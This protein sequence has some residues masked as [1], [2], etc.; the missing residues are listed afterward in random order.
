[1]RAVFD[2]SRELVSWAA[3]RIPEL[4]GQGF[5]SEAQA[6]GIEDS[7]GRTLGVVVFH[8]YEPWYGTIEVSAVSEDARWMRARD[9]WRRMHQYVF[10][11]CAC[12]KM[13]SRTPASNERAL[14]FLRALGF[15]QEAR[16]PRQFGTDDAVISAKYKEDWQSEQTPHAIAA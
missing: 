16:L 11:G 1:M 7:A 15:K 3:D 10:E 6:I 4:H 8:N 2:R 5:P 14:R 13:W 12:Q 9:A